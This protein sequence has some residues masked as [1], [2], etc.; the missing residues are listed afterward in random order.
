M[1]A[2]SSPPAKKSPLGD[3]IFAIV[4]LLLLGAI[5]VYAVV[6]LVLGNAHRSVVIFG[7]LVLYYVLVLHGPLV[8]EIKRRRAQKSTAQK[9]NLKK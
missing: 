6:S 4:H 7:C 2:K 1:A 9:G 8:R 5:F 3:T